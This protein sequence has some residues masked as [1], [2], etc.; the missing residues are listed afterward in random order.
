MLEITPTFEEKGDPL[1]IQLYSFLKEEIQS[2]N[3]KTGEGILLFKEAW[4]EK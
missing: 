4:F 2:G 1:Y 3:I